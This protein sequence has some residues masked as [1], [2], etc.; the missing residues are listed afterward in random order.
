[1]IKGR[2]RGSARIKAAPAVILVAGGTGAR[3]AKLPVHAADLGQLVLNILV[4]GHA[5]P[6]LIGLK[7]LV[8][9]LAL[10]FKLGM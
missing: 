8:A 5:L 6:G 3:I 9:V 2:Q 10:R 4:A 7:R 1:M